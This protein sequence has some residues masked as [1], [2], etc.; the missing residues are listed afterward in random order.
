MSEH[1]DLAEQVAMWRRAA[2]RTLQGQ[3][4]KE[5]I[6]NPRGLVPPSAGIDDASAQMAVDLLQAG[7]LPNP[8]QLAS[9]AQCLR[10]LRTPL[11]VTQ[12]AI[13]DPAPALPDA[14][15]RWR[16]G[17]WGAFMQR[18]AVWLRAVCRVDRAEGAPEGTAFLVGPELVMTA[19][20]VVMEISLG[21]G[22]LMRGQAT[23]RFGQERNTLDPNPP[24]DVVSVMFLDVELDIA[25]LKI[26]RTPDSVAPLVLSSRPSA[27]HAEVAAVGYPRKDASR[28]L[29]IGVAI[30]GEPFDVKRVAPGEI[31]KLLSGEFRHDCCTLGGNSGS[32]MLEVATGNVLGVHVYGLNGWYNVAVSADSLARRPDLKDK[33]ERWAD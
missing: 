25:L 12:G 7:E 23:V 1:K 15:P 10:L 8:A 28:N 20:H 17:Q 3:R 21:V 4:V 6:N 31:I 16:P 29:G 9:L 22:R 33:I 13:V 19:G 32:P 14:E 5:A 24:I 18:S 26:D 30:F 27:L 2:E 11:F